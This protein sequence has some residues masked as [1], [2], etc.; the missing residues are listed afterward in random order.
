MRDSAFYSIFG[1]QFGIRC[2]LQNDHFP[3]VRRELRTVVISSVV[4]PDSLQS[5]DE[6]R[7]ARGRQN[8]E[9]SLNR[10]IEGLPFSLPD[11]RRT[12]GKPGNAER[13]DER[14]S[15]LT[16]R[17]HKGLGDEFI[18]RSM[19]YISRSSFCQRTF[20]PIRLPSCCHCEP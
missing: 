1:Q 5:L 7:V 8:F 16:S 20:V 6:V 9:D 13:R 18:H 11:D 17:S 15:K 3:R 12:Q 4:D 2:F 10:E 14:A 19:P